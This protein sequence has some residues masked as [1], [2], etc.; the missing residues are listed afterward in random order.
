MGNEKK[1]STCVKCK[2]KKYVV[3][4]VLTYKNWS[5]TYSYYV[6]VE[7]IKEEFGHL[8]PFKKS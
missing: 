4:M 7:C 1:R 6:C 3:N 8:R 2:Q 5:D